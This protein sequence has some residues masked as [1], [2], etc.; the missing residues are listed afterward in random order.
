MV[1]KG[2]GGL[3]RQNCHRVVTWFT[4]AKTTVSEMQQRSSSCSFE[5]HVAFTSPYILSSFPMAQKLEHD[6][7]KANKTQSILQCRTER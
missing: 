3:K 5:F 1:N 2:C 7:K 6:P 4:S